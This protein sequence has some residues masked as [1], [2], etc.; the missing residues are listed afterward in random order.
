[1]FDCNQLKDIHLE[2]TSRCQASCPMCLRNYHGGLDNP[3][4]ELHDWTLDDFK[5]RIPDALLNRLHG[6]FFCGNLGDP[7]INN[8]LHNMIE[9]A[10]RVNP[11]L[12]IRIHTNGSARN[13]NWWERLAHI[14]P[15][16]HLVTFALDGLEDTHTLY[17]IGTSYNKIIENATTFINAGGLAEWC[18]IKFKHNE[19]Q[20][21]QAE[22]LAN[23]LGF[24]KFTVKN[25]S[26]FV[27]SSSFD[28]RDSNNNITHYLEPPTDMYAPIITIDDLKRYKELT[29]AAE[30]TC[31]V[32]QEKS[33]YIDCIG[34][35]YPC[36][37]LG[38]IPFMTLTND[39]SIQV[40]LE[41]KKQWKDIID[42]LGGRENINSSQ[43]TIQEIITDVR[44]QK[45]WNYIWDK[46]KNI[47]CAKTCGSVNIAKPIDQKRLIKTF[48]V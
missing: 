3:L 36:C 43:R 40:K 25:T 5:Q 7:I 37:W 27:G 10:V 32:K 4:I 28:V 19:H 38:S 17:R 46:D 47:M 34:D 6:F 20:A 18:F 12:Y 15:K 42:S 48:E 45:I 11:N 26:R 23:T 39:E 44:W 41:M 9:Y 14:L 29:H 31:V 21:L 22:Q 2:I 8:N 35:V 1:M 33:I 13:K 24:K 16:Q 30:I